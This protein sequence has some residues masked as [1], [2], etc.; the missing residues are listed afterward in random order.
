M[1]TNIVN[2]C[3]Y[4][5]YVNQHDSKTSNNFIQN[6]LLMTFASGLLLHFNVFCKVTLRKNVYP[7][8]DYNQIHRDEQII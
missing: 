4:H 1:F 3:M 2:V 7:T 5:K 8:F 6:V